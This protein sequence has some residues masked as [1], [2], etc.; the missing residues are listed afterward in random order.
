MADNGVTFGAEGI[1]A[2]LQADAAGTLKNFSKSQAEPA[3]PEENDVLV[4]TANNFE[5][6][7]KGKNVFVF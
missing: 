3:Q 6:N 1:Q 2:F 5:R 7:V 4:L